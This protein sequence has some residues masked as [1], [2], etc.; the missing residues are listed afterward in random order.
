[1]DSLPKY[2]VMHPDDSMAPIFWDDEEVG[3]GYY[4]SISMGD[5]EIS[6]SQIHGLEEWYNEADKY[7]P[8][9][10]FGTFTKDGMEEWINQ[11]YEFAKLINKLLPKEVDLYYGFWHQ[12][13]D[14]RWRFC[15]AYISRA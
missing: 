14:E 9:T 7:D 4:E 3:I 13:G 1:M 6:L 2:I 11:G 12:F 10:N 15:K 5:D 8:Y